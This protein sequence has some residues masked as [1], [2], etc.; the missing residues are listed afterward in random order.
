MCLKN[1]QSVKL[2]SPQVRFF[3]LA[4]KFSGSAY[5]KLDIHFLK[6][7]DLVIIR[8]EVE[9]KVAFPL[10]MYTQTCFKIDV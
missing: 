7:Y 4:V 2:S 3:F 5:Y 9:K 1:F 8:E 10:D 6:E